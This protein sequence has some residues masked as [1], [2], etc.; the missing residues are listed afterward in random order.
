[1]LFWKKKEKNNNNFIIAFGFVLLWISL[2]YFSFILILS[3]NFWEK[4][5]SY[6]WLTN[7]TNFIELSYWYLQDYYAIYVWLILIFLIIIKKYSSQEQFFKMKELSFITIFM[8]FVL[9][10]FFIMFSSSI[11][12]DNPIYIFKPLNQIEDDKTKALL[13]GS[14]KEEQWKED[15]LEWYF[16]SKI[17]IIDKSNEV[18]EK[19]IN[20]KDKFDIFYQEDDAYIRI[21][22]K[23]N[24][25]DYFKNINQSEKELENEVNK[26]ESEVVNALNKESKKD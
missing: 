9:S 10:F 25:K 16:Y 13:A 24:I 22:K 21:N 5:N 14:T 3:L 23:Y 17:I 1:M 19:L 12:K 4:L 26:L 7:S 15:N 2:L 18:N 20:L 6:L 11:N 8:L